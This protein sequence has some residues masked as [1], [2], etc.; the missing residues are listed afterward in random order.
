MLIFSFVYFFI[1]FLLNSDELDKFG[2]VQSTFWREW[3]LKL[4]ERKRVTD[5][6]RVLEQL[7]PGVQA[8]RFLSG[9]KDYIENTVFSLIDSLKIEK[10]HILN[11]ILKLVNTY[12]LNR[13]EVCLLTNKSTP[14]I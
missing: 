11:D 13:S 5:Q 14:L 9:D 4:D 10:K 2:K 12:S 7:I 1:Q 3:K 6:S 8:V